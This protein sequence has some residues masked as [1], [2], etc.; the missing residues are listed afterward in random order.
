MTL[1]ARVRAMTGQRKSSL[2]RRE[3]ER[4][5]RPNSS[6]RMSLSHTK[7]SGIRVGVGWGTILLLLRRRRRR[8]RPPCFYDR[9]ALNDAR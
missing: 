7:L 8:Q 4:V 5:M 2:A 3:R 1:L 9:R 6:S